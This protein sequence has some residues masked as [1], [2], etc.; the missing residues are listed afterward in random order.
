MS[1]LSESEWE[2]YLGN[3]QKEMIKEEWQLPAG[4][5][6]LQLRISNK[7]REKQC[8]CLV[9]FLREALNQQWL[10][11]RVRQGSDHYRL[12]RSYQRKM[13]KESLEEW[14]WSPMWCGYHRDHSQWS[15]GRAVPVLRAVNK[16]LDQ[17]WRCQQV[18][19]MKPLHHSCL[20][21]K[22]KHGKKQP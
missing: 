21:A 6:Q 2:Q 17:T 8:V 16:L 14:A 11:G 3:A 19:R 22:I 13:E 20:F 9:K 10:L 7:A 12:L 15:P 4:L 1:K 5:G 18:S